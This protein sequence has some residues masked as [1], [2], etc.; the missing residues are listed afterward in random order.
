MDNAFFNN[1]KMNR[2]RLLAYGFAETGGGYAWAADL[3]GG[4]FTLAV[5]ISGDGKIATRVVDCASQEEYVLFRVADAVG[6]FVGKVRQ[7]HDD[8][9]AEIAAHC[10][11]A[12]VFKSA[13]AHNVIQ[14]IAGQYGDSPEFLWPRTPEN[15]IFR[16]RDNAKWYA[17]LLTVKKAKIGLQPGDEK[18]EILDLR[19]APD[20]VDALID[21]EKYFPGYHMNKRHWFTICLNGSLPS[22]EIFAR[23][24][25]SYQLARKK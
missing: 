23:I 21:Q 12:N 24:D 20:E 2:E 7:A 25:A 14:Y 10:F 15:A 5:F 19:I 17:A 22:G 13:D 11:D 4:Q 1:R 18:I 8:K 3:L 9:L 16:R 6:G